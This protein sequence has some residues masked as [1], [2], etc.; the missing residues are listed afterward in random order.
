MK[1]KKRNARQMWFFNRFKAM[2]T[3]KANLPEYFEWI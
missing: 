3:N 2:I 1:K